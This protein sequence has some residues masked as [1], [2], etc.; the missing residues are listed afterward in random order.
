MKEFAPADVRSFVSFYNAT[1]ER[2]FKVNQYV[3]CLTA[4]AMKLKKSRFAKCVKK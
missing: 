3:W 4:Q 1:A 2:A